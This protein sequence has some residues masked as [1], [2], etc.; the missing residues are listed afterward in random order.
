MGETPK[1]FA[2]SLHIAILAVTVAL[3]LFSYLFIFEAR[4]IVP[5]DNIFD[6]TDP[7]IYAVITENDT[8]EVYY[9]GFL[10]ETVDSLENHN[11]EITIYSSIDDVPE[12][13]RAIIEH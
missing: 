12:E 7:S 5:E 2:K 10:L 6:A 3:Y 13:L 8:Y 9:G 11:S 4:Y 1:P